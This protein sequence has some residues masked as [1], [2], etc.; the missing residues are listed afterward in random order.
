MK[1]SAVITVGTATLGALVGAGG[2]GQPILTGV[3][4]ASVPLILEGAVP[5]AAARARGGGRVR[6]ARARDR[7]GGAAAARR[8]ARRRV[9]RGP[10]RSVSAASA[11]PPA[12]TAAAR[13]SAER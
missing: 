4:L 7:A 13:T 3:R 5:A 1:T 8:G 6:A 2:Y 10:G 9:T 12:A 11:P